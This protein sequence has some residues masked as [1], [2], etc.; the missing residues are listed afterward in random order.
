MDSV[1]VQVRSSTLDLM[2]EGLTI[3]KQNKTVK[4]NTQLGSRAEIGQKRNS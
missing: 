2:W 4:V 1:S 3:L